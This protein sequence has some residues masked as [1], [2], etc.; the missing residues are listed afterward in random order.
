MWI[1]GEKKSL[2]AEF[3]SIT[4]SRELII[5]TKSCLNIHAI[6]TKNCSIM[7]ENAQTYQNMHSSRLS[8]VSQRVT[9][10]F[11]IPNWCSLQ[12]CKA[13]HQIIVSVWFYH[14]TTTVGV[15]HFPYLSK[16]SFHQKFYL[17]GFFLSCSSS[18]YLILK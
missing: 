1:C 9:Q 14:C 8:Y 12:T 7:H 13:N 10:N 3:G 11:P 16:E 15:Y 4:I 5:W 18:L 2:F 17:P 6:C